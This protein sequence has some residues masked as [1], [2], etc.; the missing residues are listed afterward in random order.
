MPSR[1]QVDAFVAQ[2]VGGDHV[3]A[4]RDWYAEDAWMQE[5]LGARRQG[6]DFLMAYEA[7]MLE[8]SERV[9]TELLDPPMIADD[10]VA[11]HWRFTFHPKGGQGRTLSFEEIAWQAWRDGKVAEEIFFYDPSQMAG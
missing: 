2:V 6:R 8:R 1:E 3:G 5:N 10:K 4:I 7:K 9:D 11:L